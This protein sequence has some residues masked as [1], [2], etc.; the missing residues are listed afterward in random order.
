MGFDSLFTGISGLNAYQ[1]QIDLISND[2]ANVGTVGFKGQDMTFADLFYQSQGYASGP[3]QSSGGINPQQIGLGVKVNS[4]DTDFSQGGLETTGI[5]TNLAVNG[6][7]F[8]ILQNEDGSGQPIYTRDGDFSLNSNGLLYDPASGMA[9]QGYMANSAGVVTAGGVT[10]NITIPI[11][12]ESQATGTG[13]GTKIGPAGDDNF[14]VAMGGNLDQSQWQAEE[15]GII[16]GTGPG[17]GQTD[18]ISTTVYDSLGNA[19]QAFVKYV[20]EATGATPASVAE[21]GA[22]GDTTGAVT[23]TPGSLANVITITSQ[24]P[25]NGYTISDANGNATTGTAGEAMTFDGASFTLSTPEP[26]LGNANTLTITG[27]T[28]GLPS[29]VNNSSG[30]AVAPATRWKVEVYFTDGTDVNGQSATEAS[31]ATLGYAYYDQNGQ[32]INTSSSLGTA[33][34]AL[35]TDLHTL[36]SQPSIADGDELN[37]SAWGVLNGNGASAP[38]GSGVGVAAT[39]PIGLDFSNTTSLAAASGS[40]AGSGYTATVI[41]QNGYAAGTLSN[42]TVGQDGTITGSFTNGQDKTLGQVALATFQNEGGLSRV[43]GN[44]FQTT[45]NSGLAQVS[46][47]NKGRFGAII[48]GSLEESN[49]SLADEFTKM[50]VAQRA[51]E[52][53]TRGISTADQNLQDV[54]ALRASE[55]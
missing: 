9:V 54:I 6:D 11:G 22:G 34:S 52:A 35:T 8:F 12:L 23:V 5:N 38:T 18:T 51:F 33:G 26:A 13:F 27:A 1:D 16:D 29:S 10:S 32:F 7:G 44:G 49:V 55:N 14:D 40:A 3:T 15:Q 37:I 42:I 30:T 19:H 24:G 28:T 31:P 45:A 4:I 50:I 2:I 20:P 25:G 46:T 21:T 53:N 47:A 39:G 17:S 43:G 41:S 36:G 48:A